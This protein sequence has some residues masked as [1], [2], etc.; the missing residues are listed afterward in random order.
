VTDSSIASGRRAGN[1]LTVWIF[2]HYALP[3][4]EAGGSRHHAIGRTLAQWGHRVVVIASDRSYHSPLTSRLA[5]GETARVEDHDG[6]SFLWVRTPAYASNGVARFRNMLSY[7]W[8]TGIGGALDG[9]PDPDV[10]IGSSPH[11]FAA[12]AAL[13]RARAKRKPFILEVRDLW[14]QSLIDV[15][16]VSERHPAVLLFSAIERLLYRQARTIV[17]LMPGAG[18]HIARVAGKA[19]DVVCVQNSVDTSLLPAATPIPQNGRFTFMYAG[20]HGVANG[21]DVVLDA[22]ARL[23]EQGM[24]DR[25][26]I[27]LVGEGPEKARLIERSKQMAL[28]SVEFEAAVPKQDVYRRLAEADSFLMLLRDS[29]VFRFG[30]SPN[31]L[32]DYL[33][34]GRPVIFGIGTPFNPIAESRAGITVP[35]SDPDALAAAMLQMAGVDPAE[36]Q[37][38][39]DR[40]RAYVLENHSFESLSRRIESVCARAVSG[41]SVRAGVK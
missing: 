7:A 3:V 15:A 26:R 24:A 28:R 11:P 12:L 36:R 16:G 38:M 2:N 13:R 22:A 8:R 5:A 40:G 39:A 31:K 17:P 34:V 25:I 29:P 4:S 18:E 14:P 32:F 41:N 35:P 10:I 1:P 20:A 6:V 30:I 21:L 9:L 33:A 37:A 19:C 27:R 23:E